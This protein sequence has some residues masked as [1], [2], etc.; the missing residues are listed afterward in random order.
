MLLLGKGL[1]T[2]IPIITSKG[3]IE[4]GYVMTFSL[5]QVKDSLGCVYRQMCSLTTR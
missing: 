3:V 4:L 2:E 1:W 5:L